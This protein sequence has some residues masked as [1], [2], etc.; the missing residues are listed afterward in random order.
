MAGP[1]RLREEFI[2]CGLD[3][4]HCSCYPELS[5]RNLMVSVE[6]KLRAGM[7]FVV[8]FFHPFHCDVGV[9]LGCRQF[10]VPEQRLDASQVRAVIQKMGGEAMAKFVRADPELDGGL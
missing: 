4:C 8:G 1:R 2:E 10:G 5:L 3:L 7:G 6:E 9:N